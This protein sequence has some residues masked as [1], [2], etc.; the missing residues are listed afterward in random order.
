M[1]MI[2]CWWAACCEQKE[3]KELKKKTEKKHKGRF[4]PAFSKKKNFYRV[5]ILFLKTHLFVPYSFLV[6]L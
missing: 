3:K 6:A 1:D 2:C 5:F 4:N